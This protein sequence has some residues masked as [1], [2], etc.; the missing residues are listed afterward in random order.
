MLCSHTGFSLASLIYITLVCIS[1]LS[2]NYI[3]QTTFQYV[4]KPDTLLYLAQEFSITRCTSSDLSCLYA[5]LREQIVYANSFLAMFVHLYLFPC[6]TST[7]NLVHAGWMR[8]ARL[9]FSLAR[10][11]I[12]NSISQ[13]QSALT[14]LRR[15]STHRISIPRYEFFC[16]WF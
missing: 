3:S 11:L 13:V 6:C 7:L 15:R 5:R 2:V 9:G 10:Q 14:H 4:A 12:W 1:N 8:E 16:Y